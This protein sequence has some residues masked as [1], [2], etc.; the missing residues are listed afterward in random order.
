MIYLD[1]NAT[2]PLCPEAG[3]AMKP[4]LEGTWG[5]PSGIHA[6]AR[7]TRAVIDEARDRLA[8]LL[9][10]KPHGFAFTGGGT[11][12]CNLALLG[13]ARRHRAPGRDHL[14]T[15]ST[16]HHAVLHAMR[17]L[18]HREGFRLTEIPVDSRGLVD[19]SEFAATLGSG[20]ILASVMLANNE[21]G[22]IQPI[23]ELAAICR[24]RGVLLHTDAVQ[25]FGKIPC[26]PAALGVDALSA[27]SHK[28]YGPHGAGFLWL[29]SG[30]SI[31]SIQHGGYHE[32]ERRP[33]TENAA[34][35]TGMTMAAE[36]AI[37]EACEGIESARQ[38]ALREILWKGIRE[39]FPTAIRNAAGAVVIANT[40]NVSFPGCDGETLLMGLDLEGVAVSSGS[41]C[42]VGSIMPS[43]VLLAM[44]VPEETARATV[45]FSLGRAT[46]EEEIAST[47]A[48]LGRVLARQA[49][50]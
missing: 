10:E 9:G 21:T 33:G 1:H 28:F 46:T 44:G 7:R 43:H 30:L 41:A 24:E 5:N 11:E 12:S 4:L 45:R 32:N 31:E 48:A 15:V 18:A 38:A 17:S 40:L 37:A 36:R 19:P 20:T 27:T 35:I 47:I 6:S 16:E 49:R 22:V 2:T 39:L 8:G 25:A 42:M 26:H 23:A 29:R 13:L 34:A 14:V 50:R 3:E